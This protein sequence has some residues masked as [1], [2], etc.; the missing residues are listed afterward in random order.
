MKYAVIIEHAGSNYS[1]YSPDVPGCIAAAKTVEETLRLFKEA[2][3][4]HFESLIQYG[5]PIPQPTTA[6]EYVEPQIPIPA[7]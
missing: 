5:E 7:A 1:A 2:M 6:C 3:E 4:F